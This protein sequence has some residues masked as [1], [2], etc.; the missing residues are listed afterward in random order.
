MATFFEALA[1][2][3]VRPGDI[4]RGV[5]NQAVRSLAEL[6]DAAAKASKYVAILVERDGNPQFLAIRLG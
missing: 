6:K 1:A 2:A 3:G 5:N 4:I